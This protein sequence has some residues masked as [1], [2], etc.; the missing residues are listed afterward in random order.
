M[1]RWLWRGN[2]R[3][4]LLQGKLARSIGIRT[5]I[6]VWWHFAAAAAALAYL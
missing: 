2:I 4:S 6:T 1:Q 5:Y 3:C